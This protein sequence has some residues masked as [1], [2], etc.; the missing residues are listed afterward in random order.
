MSAPS[1]RPPVKAARRRPVPPA[2]VIYERIVS[3]IFEHRLAP[4]TKLVEDRLVDIFGANRSRIRAVLARLA[5]EQ[6][7]RLEPNRGAFVAA[8]TPREAREIFECR[9]L[10]EPGVVRRL[11]ETIDRRGIDRL[12]ALVRAEATARAD[13]DRRAIIRMSGEF[14][15]ALAE[16]AGN[17][18]LTRSMRELATLTCLIIFLYDAPSIPSCHGDEHA[19]IT[20]AIVRKDAQRAVALMLHHLDHV[21]N[22]LSL[23]EPR[24]VGL[25]LEQVF[26]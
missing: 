9:R 25:D 8:P 17:S 4:G 10:I 1:G 20:E 5:H 16:L 13:N 21:E 2:D 18:F 19:D 22:N 11:A 12:R 26:A 23:Q 7:V 3:A 24:P 15:I 6:L 14:H